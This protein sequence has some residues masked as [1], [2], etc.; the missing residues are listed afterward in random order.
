[1]K[2]IRRF[3]CLF[4][5]AI[6]LFSANTFAQI[7]MDLTAGIS[8]PCKA[9]NL[10]ISNGILFC[11]T[12]Q[13]YCFDNTTFGLIIKYNRWA[14]DEDKILKYIESQIGPKP[15]DI[16]FGIDG[17]I[18]GIIIAPTIRVQTNNITGPKMFIGTS[19]GYYK[20]NSEATITVENISLPY[21]ATEDDVGASIYGGLTLPIH[22]KI[23]LNINVVYNIILYPDIFKY[24][25]PNG[26]LRFIF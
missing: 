22:P 14:Y 15:A 7:A 4:C 12:P 6:L 18:N 13:I 16:S 19:L 26:G 3:S 10:S 17:H 25:E 23:S 5:A 24:Y 2:S 11:A 1:M 20:M 21:K 8:V 9:K